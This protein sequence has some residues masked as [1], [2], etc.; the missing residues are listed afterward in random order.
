MKIHVY[1]LLA[2]E[3]LGYSHYRAQS[4]FDS[5]IDNYGEIVVGDE[6]ITVKMNRKRSL[7]LLR[8]SIPKLNEPYPWLGGKKLIFTANTHT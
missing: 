2:L 4:L 7:P 5:F 1:R 6:E 3:L 8:E